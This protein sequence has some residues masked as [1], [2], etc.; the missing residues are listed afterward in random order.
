M[1]NK[2]SFTIGGLLLLGSL[3]TTAIAKPVSAEPLSEQSDS[4][5]RE[6]LIS[7]LRGHETYQ[8]EEQLNPN[9]YVYGTVRGAAGSILSIELE[10]GDS[11]Q[12]ESTAARPG[13][14]VI[15]TQEGD[16]YEFVGQAQPA[17]IL[18]LQEDYKLNMAAETGS[19]TSTTS[20]QEETQMEQTD[21]VTPEPAPVPEP[22][23]TEPAPVPEEQPEEPVRGMW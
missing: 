13:D 17:W 5:S 10:E 2:T 18:T 15:L 9:D 23:Q 22:Q 11:I 3:A 19:A 21:T 7:Q 4:N 16:D 8:K 1:L 14:D 6:M 12:V 20:V